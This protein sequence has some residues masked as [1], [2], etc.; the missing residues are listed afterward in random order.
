[1]DNNHALTALRVNGSITV[2]TH[3]PCTHTHTHTHT[4]IHSP[5]HTHTHTHAHTRPHTPTHTHTHTHTHKHTQEKCFVSLIAWD[6]IKMDQPQAMH[7]YKLPVVWPC[8]LSIKRVTKWG[9][10]KSKSTLRSGNLTY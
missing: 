8:A 7:I 6:L 3:T 2:C 5:T 1:M 9:L 4:S 10:R